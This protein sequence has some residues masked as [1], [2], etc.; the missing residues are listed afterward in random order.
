[1]CDM[2]AILKASWPAILRKTSVV[3]NKILSTLSRHY[4][5]FAG[6][7]DYNGESVYPRQG[8]QI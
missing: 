7:S 3:K 5:R 6:G 8:V 1:M 4:V 2:P